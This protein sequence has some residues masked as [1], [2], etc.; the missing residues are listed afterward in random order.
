MLFLYTILLFSSWIILSR[1]HQQFKTKQEYKCL[2]AILLQ[3]DTYDLHQFC[4][5]STYSN[6]DSIIRGLIVDSVNEADVKSHYL[7][8][9]NTRD[10]MF[11]S[12]LHI[13]GNHCLRKQYVQ[14]AKNVNKVLNCPNCPFLTTKYNAL[15]YYSE[16]TIYDGCWYPQT[17]EI[18]NKSISNNQMIRKFIGNKETTIIY[19]PE[20]RISAVLYKW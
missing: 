5:I 1:Y 17:L 2:S 9:L 20:M 11:E 12:I 4:N 19:T 3:R 6:Q 16:K 7:S 8:L 15:R 14:Y 18:L 10:N 13:Q